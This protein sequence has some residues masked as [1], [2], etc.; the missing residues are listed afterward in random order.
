MQND[1]GLTC[2]CGSENFERVVIRRLQRHDYRTDFV[3]CVLCRVM[4]HVPEPDGSADPDLE[5][6]AAIAARLY[7]KPG[8]C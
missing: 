4:F 3:A 6:D 7:R 1:F 8:R 5:H 2:A